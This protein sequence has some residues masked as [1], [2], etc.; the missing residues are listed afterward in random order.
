LPGIKAY[1][2]RLVDHM[3]AEVLFGVLDEVEARYAGYFEGV[4]V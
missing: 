4:E 2:A 1:R 3:E